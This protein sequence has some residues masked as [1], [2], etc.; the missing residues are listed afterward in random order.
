MTV[1]DAMSKIHSREFMRWRIYFRRLDEKK[2]TEDQPLYHYLQQIAAEIR[3]TPA[4][5]KRR[6]IPYDKFKI[7]FEIDKKLPAEENREERMR[8]SKQAWGAFFA[9]A[10][11]NKG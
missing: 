10:S 7:K 3:M 9:T 5:G 2:W 6:N 11:R 1:G 8:K 4:M